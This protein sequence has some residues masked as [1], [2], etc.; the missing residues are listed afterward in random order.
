VNPDIPYL[1]GAILNNR[2]KVC[3]MAIQRQGFGQVLDAIERGGRASLPFP[4]LAMPS[5]P[6]QQRRC[7]EIFAQHNFPQ[8]VNTSVR[9]ST[10]PHDRIRLGYFSSDFHEHPVSYLSA[11]MFELHDRSKFEVFA[12]SCGASPEDA[13]RKRLR[14]GFDHFLEVAGKRTEDIAAIAQNAGIDIAIDLG[15][16]TKNSPIGVFAHRAAPVQVHFLGYP[17]T[18]GTSCI[19]YLIA[20]RIVIPEG[21]EGFYS[22]RI[23]YLPD[24][25]LP[26]DSK[27]RIADRVFSREELGLP[28][29]GFVFCCFN[30]QYKIGPLVFDSWVRLLKAVE[31]SVLWLSAGNP[32]SAKNLRKEAVAQGV[33]AERIIFAERFNAHEEHLARQWAAD[34]FLDTFPY[35]A[36]TT[37]SD[38]LWAGLPVLTFQGSTFAGRVAASLLS[39]IGLPEMITLSIEEYEALAIKLATQPGKLAAI[40]QKLS[41]HRLSYPLFD[42][43]RFTRNI[44]AAYLQMWKRHQAKLAPEH[45]HV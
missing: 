27:R 40:R 12:F 43:P 29:T 30:N 41:E 10:D 31:G 6:A 32:T 1:Q 26:G 18:L 3:D 5:T 13:L 2:M 38:A 16:Y 33:A 39:T 9:S 34:L 8:R 4:L 28:P 20:D 14:K 7:A 35:N 36:H 15:G 22:E 17:G 44:E 25:F 24:S 21:Q 45:I 11:E 42:T 23:A 37:A 19:D